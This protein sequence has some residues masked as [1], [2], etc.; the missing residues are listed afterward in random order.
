MVVIAVGGGGGTEITGTSS[1]NDIVG[2][3][4]DNTALAYFKVNDD[5]LD[6]ANL[7]NGLTAV[8]APVNAND[9]IMVYSATGAAVGKILIGDMPGWAV[10]EKT[11]SADTAAVNNTTTPANVGISFS[12][13]SGEQYRFK[14]IIPYDSVV[15]LDITLS[16]T[17]AVIAGRWD[18][19]QGNVAANDIGSAVTTSGTGSNRVTAIEGRF[20]CSTSGTVAV[21]FAQS[22]ATVGD[23]KVL[24][25]AYI[26]VV[27]AN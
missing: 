9:S 26:E 4:S 21:Q 24:A 16:L 25:G 7:I 10:F 5:N 8:T 11:L 19:L 17:T 14:L 27:K 12:V 18:Y 23:S 1:A 20:S 2:V 22:S 6:T 15:T 3:N 13:V